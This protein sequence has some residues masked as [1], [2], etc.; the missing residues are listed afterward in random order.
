MLI[1][2]FNC[3]IISLC[4]AT[5]RE[6]QHDPTHGIESIPTE[7]SKYVYKAHHF[8]NITSRRRLNT[9]DYKRKQH[10]L[11]KHHKHH[12]HPP[13]ES[14]RKTERTKVKWTAPASSAALTTGECFQQIIL[15]K[16]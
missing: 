15:F 13:S 14:T 11:Q 12:K 1:Y 16:Y 7:D 8:A 9:E 3:L 6:Y 2:S 4:L 10:E 5:S